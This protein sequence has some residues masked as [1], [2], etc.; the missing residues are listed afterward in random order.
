MLPPVGMHLP[1]AGAREAAHGLQP[2]DD[3]HEFARG[4]RLREQ[5]AFGVG[6]F[7]GARYPGDFVPF[8]VKQADANARRADGKGARGLHAGALPVRAAPNEAAKGVALQGEGGAG[9]CV[10]VWNKDIYPMQIS[11]IAGELCRRRI[12]TH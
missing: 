11:S 7:V 1:D 4:E 6:Q 8:G 3:G 9:F 12:D 5:F 2:F 10:H